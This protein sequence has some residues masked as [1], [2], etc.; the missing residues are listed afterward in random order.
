MEQL[1]KKV[2]EQTQQVERLGMIA[3][4]CAPFV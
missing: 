1:M 2:Q 3:R 4:K